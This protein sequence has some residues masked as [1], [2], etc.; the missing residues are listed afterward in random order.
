V[1][2]Y[3]GGMNALLKGASPVPDRVSSLQQYG[4][5]FVACG[6]TLETI[7]KTPEDLLPGVKL[8]EAG[9]AEI[10]ERRLTGWIYIVP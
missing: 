5:E 3:A 10:V 9:I 6:N 1:I 8:V 7:H 2:A 4:V